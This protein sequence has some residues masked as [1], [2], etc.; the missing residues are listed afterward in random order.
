[1]F[2][3]KQ[4]VYLGYKVKEVKTKQE[5]K[6]KVVAYIQNQPKTRKYKEILLKAFDGQGIVYYL[7][8]TKYGHCVM[9]TPELE[10]VALRVVLATP[11]KK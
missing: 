4:I 1:M 7:K 6:M 11:L 8:S 9:V 10:E 5:R 3:G 2:H